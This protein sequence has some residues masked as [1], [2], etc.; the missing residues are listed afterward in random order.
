MYLVRR[1]CQPFRN[2]YFKQNFLFWAKISVWNFLLATQNTLSAASYIYRPSSN[3]SIAAWTQKSLGHLYHFHIT[4][5]LKH[6][7]IY[8]LFSLSRSLS[9]C[10][11]KNIK[12]FI[13]K[14]HLKIFAAPKKNNF[15]SIAVANEESVF[16]TCICVRENTHT[17]IHI[18]N[19]AIIQHKHTHTHMHAAHIA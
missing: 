9:V 14:F 10:V 7:P 8:I 13:N 1:L 19:H 2:L 17:N 16:G 5:W 11:M 18:H 15:F 6:F 3:S 4:I 12:L